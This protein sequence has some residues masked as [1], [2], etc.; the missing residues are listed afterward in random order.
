MAKKVESTETPILPP[1][2]EQK[3]IVA[4][5]SELPPDAYLEH[6]NTDDRKQHWN[7][8]R[9]GFTRLA[10]MLIAYFSGTPELTK[11]IPVELREPFILWRDRYL[12]LYEM[13]CNGW[14][15]IQEAAVENEL[16]IPDSPT[17][18]LLKII[19]D[20]S[21]EIF[22]KAFPECVTGNAFNE[23][24]PRKEYNLR[25]ENSH[26]VRLL[27]ASAQLKPDEQKR[28]Q[29]HR[30]ELQKRSPWNQFFVRELFCVHTCTQAAKDDRALKKRVKAFEQADR[31][32][33]SDLY[34]A[35]HPRKKP[36]GF[37]FSKGKKL[38]S[39][40]GGAYK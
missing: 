11:Q 16:P 28:I 39:A 4:A 8:C 18:M 6:C 40:P 13:L 14:S 30:K 38:H 21:D 33:E 32:C 19:N 26:V 3:I 1:E 15:Y 12:A 20:Q 9:V 25:R 10:I 5:V 31:D 37:A 22:L 29:K 36:R 27:K 23:F 2:S 35:I 34:G 24:S 17:Q 7:E